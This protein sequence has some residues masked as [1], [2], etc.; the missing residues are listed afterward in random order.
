MGRLWTGAE[1][2]RLRERSPCARSEA[3]GPAAPAQLRLA[4]GGFC[5]LFSIEHG[6]AAARALLA[7]LVCGTR[8]AYLRLRL[9]GAGRRRLL[10]LP[11]KLKPASPCSIFRLRLRLRPSN[12]LMQLGDARGE[13]GARCATASSS[14][15]PRY[16][17][18]RRKRRRMGRLPGRTAA[19]GAASAIAMQLPD[20]LASRRRAYRS[21]TGSRSAPQPCL[22]PTASGRGCKRGCAS[23]APPPAPAIPMGS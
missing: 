18:L 2:T 19:A 3:D 12:L 10:R 20:E 15:R 7:S 17:A 8:I 6:S 13:A 23:L 22:E 21:E 11:T 1:D 5:G 9:L 16:S 14:S 4:P